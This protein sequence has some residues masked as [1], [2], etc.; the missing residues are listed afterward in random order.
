MKRYLRA[1]WLMAKMVILPDLM[2]PSAAI[3]FIIGKVARFA[4]YF[5]FLYSVVSGIE[6]FAGYTK[7]EV[8]WFFLV[9]NLVDISVQF[10]FRGVYHFRPLVVSGNFDLELL[11]PLPSFFRPLFGHIDIMDFITLIPLTGFSIWYVIRFNLAVGWLSVL[12]FLVLFI[13]SLLLG[14]AFHLL[15]CSFCI[16]T[17]EIDHLVWIYRDLTAVARFPTDIYRGFMRFLITFVIPVVLLIT[18]PAKALLGLI[19]PWQVGISLGISL[20]LS[21]LS[22]K[23]WYYSLRHYSSARS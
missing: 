16:L 12:S 11:K 10:L 6:T 3:L 17:T 9:F 18:F 2:Q 19:Q 20:V 21:V 23:F 1:F 5:V 4:F 7:V 22:L 13:S 15:V 8:V 14:F